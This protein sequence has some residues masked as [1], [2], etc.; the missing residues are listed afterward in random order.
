MSIAKSIKVGGKKL[1]LAYITPKEKAMLLAKD[2]AA[3]DITK[4]FHKGVPLLYRMG[5]G[6]DDPGE[7]EAAA[8]GLGGDP[9]GGGGELTTS[10][11]SWGWEGG[12]EGGAVWSPDPMPKSVPTPT[13][14]DTSARDAAAA[15][16]KAMAEDAARRAAAERAAAAARAKVASDSAAARD[17]EM[18]ARAAA[19]RAAAAATA[20]S[21]AEATTR[22]EVHPPSTPAKKA[23]PTWSEP[24]GSTAP[25]YYAEPEPDYHITADPKGSTAGY[26]SS[27]LGYKDKIVRDEEK[28]KAEEKAE[29][30]TKTKTKT[31]YPTEPGAD[32]GGGKGTDYVPIDDV[33]PTA[34]VTNSSDCAAAGGI[35]DEATGVCLVKTDPKTSGIPSGGLPGDT[36]DGSGYDT[37]VG[38]GEP[39]DKAPPYGY[40]ESVVRPGPGISETERVRAKVDAGTPFSVSIRDHLF[41]EASGIGSKYERLAEMDEDREFREKQLAQAQSFASKGMS[42]S[43]AQLDA[44]T[45][46]IREAA[47]RRLITADQADK[48]QYELQ[49]NALRTAEPIELL[50]AAGKIG[51]A[52]YGGTFKPGAID[53][54]RFMDPARFGLARPPGF[55]GEP[56]E[57]GDSAE[58]EKEKPL[59]GTPGT[60]T[61][62]TDHKGNTCYTSDAYETSDG[63]WVCPEG[64]LTGGGEK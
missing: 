51:D 17:R 28:R 4:K 9:Y 50:A 35:W 55:S 49:M 63:K 36:G 7:A 21:R 64:K 54:S 38:R 8:R 12:K 32:A 60:E 37:D 15:R 47:K 56:E 39:L 14:P 44:E 61:H 41:G 48:L 58:G 45:D 27:V 25:S 13:P 59:D 24:G 31:E 26:I 1:G 46:M 40:K 57:V 30:E 22:R 23:A 53:T 42:F 11:G 29:S 52:G 18:A 2:S 5:G 43:T 33:D 62:H 6:P 16:S 20:A 19:D 34:K 3:G 10:G